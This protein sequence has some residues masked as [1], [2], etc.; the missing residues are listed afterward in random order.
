[1]TP[2]PQLSK[3]RAAPS[4]QRKRAGEEEG[5]VEIESREYGSDITLE[6]REMI[7]ARIFVV[8]PGIII[9]RELP[10]P[11][12]ASVKL[13]LERVTELRHGWPSFIL[14]VNLS[15]VSRPTAEVR[16]AI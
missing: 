15:G 12:V 14:I 1:M 16:D 7:L 2:K 10:I 8:Q 5:R 4:P 13:M 9:L 6:E 3:P 11:T